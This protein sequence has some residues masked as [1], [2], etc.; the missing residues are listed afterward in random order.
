MSRRWINWG[1]GIL[2]TT[3]WLSTSAGADRQLT[4]DPAARVMIAPAG[5]AVSAEKRKLQFYDQAGKVTATRELQGN[6]SV[7][8][9][10]GGGNV[11]GIMRYH[12][13]SP[14]TLTPVT[15]DLSDFSGKQLYRIENPKFSS[16]VIS[17]TGTAIVGLD[18]VEG[19]PQSTLHFFDQGGKEVASLSVEYYQG[20]QFSGDGSLFVFATAKD[21][22]LAYTAAGKA[23]AGFGQGSVFDL[24]AD[25]RTVVI[26]HQGTLRLY[27]DGKRRASVSTDEQIRAL[28]VSTQ[29]RH[30]GWASPQ[31]AVVYAVGSDSIVCLIP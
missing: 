16:V 22:V 21:G 12:D 20:G 30:F 5:Q 8:F 25:G 17:P 19:L 26:W 29:G 27:V 3:C 2:A 10:V 9:P 18:G 11:I 1:T 31:R 6:E 23:S 7:T 13:N 15:F 24:S 28:A 14:S 4:Y